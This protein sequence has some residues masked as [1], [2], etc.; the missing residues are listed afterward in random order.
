[1]VSGGQIGRGA[2]AQLECV[3]TVL[4]AGKVDRC[5]IRSRGCRFSLSCP[6]EKGKHQRHPQIDLVYANKREQ[7]LA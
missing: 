6:K 4:R 5:W 1:M 3:G 2:L 7:R